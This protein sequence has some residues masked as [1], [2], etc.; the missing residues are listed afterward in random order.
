MVGSN[1]RGFRE[2]ERLQI[3]EAVLPP[4]VQVIE[5]HLTRFSTLDVTPS[6]LVIKPGSEVQGAKIEP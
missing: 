3:G 6:P 4:V 2:P 1:L 5:H